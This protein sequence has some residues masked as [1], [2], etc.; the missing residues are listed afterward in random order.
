[1]KVIIIQAACLGDT[2]DVNLWSF[3]SFALD[4]SV[5]MDVIHNL[6]DVRLNLKLSNQASTDIIVC[7][8]AICISVQ[9]H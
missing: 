7:L 2:D 1:M 5:N 3:Q 4:S 6:L 9:F 8:T